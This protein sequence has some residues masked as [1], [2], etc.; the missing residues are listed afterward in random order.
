M[1]SLRDGSSPTGPEMALQWPR[2]T[3][4]RDPFLRPRSTPL[5][6]EVGESCAKS[7]QKERMLREPT[8]YIRLEVILRLIC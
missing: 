6:R 5:P 4:T 2:R 3:W 7:R 1:R 8:L